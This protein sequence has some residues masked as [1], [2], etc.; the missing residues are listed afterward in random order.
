MILSREC[1]KTDVISSC[2]SEKCCKFNQRKIKE[3]LQI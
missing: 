3:M 2:K 1:Q